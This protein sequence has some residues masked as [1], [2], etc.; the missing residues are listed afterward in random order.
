MKQ[1]LM[2][3][4][5]RYGIVHVNC[6]S[7]FVSQALRYHRCHLELLL[8]KS[9]PAALK[10]NFIEPLQMAPRFKV[11]K[12]FTLRDGSSILYRLKLEGQLTQ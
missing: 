12:V 3:M 1:R 11:S 9:P 4:I 7:F 5:L 10:L 2:S 6:V 8:V